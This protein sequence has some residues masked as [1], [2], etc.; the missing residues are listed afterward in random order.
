MLRDVNLGVGIENIRVIEKET[1]KRYG[2][3]S[4]Q[5]DCHRAAAPKAA[6]GGPATRAPSCVRASQQHEISRGGQSET[7]RDGIRLYGE[8]TSQ[9]RPPTGHVGIDEVRRTPNLIEPMIDPDVA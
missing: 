8:D 6:T 9:I 7:R 2:S 1:A 5:S 3:Q 4:E